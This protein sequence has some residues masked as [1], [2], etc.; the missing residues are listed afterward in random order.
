MIVP[1]GLWPTAPPLS[2]YV[3]VP[4]PPLLLSN[5]TP[6]S[7]TST[8]LQFDS[9]IFMQTFFQELK[10][11]GQ[12]QHVL[13]DEATYFCR[14]IHG[15]QLLKLIQATWLGQAPHDLWAVLYRAA[16]GA[17][18]TF[19]CNLHRP[20]RLWRTIQP[21]ALVGLLQWKQFITWHTRSNDNKS[22][23]T[24][25]SITGHTAKINECQRTAKAQV[26]IL[27]HSRHV[28]QWA[29]PQLCLSSTS[30]RWASS[31]MAV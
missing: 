11:V 24:P 14:T 31:W 16:L 10:G 1:L 28:V 9:N 20:H 8:S 22:Y 27:A 5:S 18:V 19:I 12:V 17:V 21:V 2:S 30:L 25:S 13:F 3:W 6:I 7:P 29:S 15:S 26:N 4:A 23:M